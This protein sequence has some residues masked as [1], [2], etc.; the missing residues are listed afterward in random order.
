MTDADMGTGSSVSAANLGELYAWMSA[1][2]PELVPISL[3]DTRAQ[4][5]L[6]RAH[7]RT[8]GQLALL[9]DESL[10]RLPNV[11]ARTIRHIN[12]VLRAG[13]YE[14]PLPV[15]DPKPPSGLE[16]G[17]RV[18]RRS[19]QNG[20]GDGLLQLATAAPDLDLLARL[21]KHLMVAAEWG[22]V[23][24]GKT[25]VG[26]LL[27]ALD[28]DLPVPTEV[29]TEIEQ[30]L[31]AELPQFPSL[32]ERIE[33]LICQAR[34]PTLLLA[35]ECVRERP[36]LQALASER[37]MT[38]ERIRQKVA[39]DGAIVREQLSADE[40]R[41]IRWAI[42]R[43][44]AEVGRISLID[45][46]TIRSW[47]ERLG[48]P[49]FE[50]L[51]WLSGYSYKDDW[52]LEGSAS[53]AEVK[54]ELD[55]TIA[56]EW[57]VSVELLVRRVPTFG[58]SQTVVRFLVETG[59]WRDIDAGWL[60]RWDGPIQVKAERVL[61]LA[62]TPMTPAELVAAIGH[63]SEGAI[64]NQRGERLVRVDKHFRLALP[65]WGLEEY[66]G[67]A[68]E[69]RQ[70]IKRGGGIASKSAIID[71]F[72]RDFGV[73]VSSIETNLGLP[74]F[75]VSG[76][77]VRLGD[78]TV[79]S[80]RAPSTV[81]GAVRTAAGW[82]ERHLVTENSFKGFSFTMNPHVCWANGLRPGADLLLPLNGSDS[83][84][85]SVI[86]RTTNT[87]GKVD[88]GRLRE[89]LKENA[90]PPASAVLICPTTEGVTLYVGKDEIEDARR[91]FDAKAP[92]VAPDIASLMEGL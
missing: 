8:W 44:R 71:E 45:S 52:L 66:E 34:D 23:A 65:E 15:A 6:R 91:A 59:E 25:S 21:A 73:S 60:V 81:S 14:S 13:P 20:P 47:H 9:S 57:L 28:E 18:V 87:T 48:D 54:A 27:A 26:G 64:K 5:V 67:I 76:D 90:V 36:T 41:P 17:G 74:M 78:D 83:H 3:F 62:C 33:S 7:V 16:G 84:R 30:L 88:V 42:E 80:P 40:Y 37:G 70:R 56:D 63:G 61:R 92:P 24:S 1:V 46:V 19:R 10:R 86:W 2:A 35:R 58:D 39:R 31:A 11:G 38:R 12:N 43:F 49:A 29:V 50:V 79:F 85:A 69:I 72:T 75:E 89:W 53:F 77:T 82:G 68:T 32:P 22:R 51:R 55:A 4:N